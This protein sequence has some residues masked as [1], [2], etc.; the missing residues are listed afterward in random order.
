[1]SE[2]DSAS[3]LYTENNGAIVKA[4]AFEPDN[5]MRENKVVLH[6]DTNGVFTV[7]FS[8]SERRRSRG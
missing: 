6:I 3:R 2:L 8:L 4:Q 5:P 1:M 7:I